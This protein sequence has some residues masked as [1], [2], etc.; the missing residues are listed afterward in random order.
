M[1]DFPE[2]WYCGGGFLETSLKEEK[3]DDTDSIKYAQAYFTIIES[4]RTSYSLNLQEISFDDSI[5]KRI[6]HNFGRADDIISDIKLSV[7]SCYS[8]IKLPK[9]N[10][11]HVYGVVVQTT[12][13]MELN[14]FFIVVN[15]NGEIVDGLLTYEYSPPHCI[16][17]KSCYI[18]ESYIFH[19]KHFYNVDG[20]EVDRHQPY[21]RYRISEEG[22][23]VPYS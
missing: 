17:N 5:I 13:E 14:P 23:F 22:K 8:Y 1:F 21:Q 15:N 2:H 3:L 7:K 11:Y 18:D 16:A 19:V 10:G 20:Y 4:Q 6:E 9:C 12:R